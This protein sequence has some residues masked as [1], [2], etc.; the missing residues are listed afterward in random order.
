MSKYSNLR[1]DVADR[2]LLTELSKMVA[3]STQ[4]LGSAAYGCNK[5]IVVVKTRRRYQDLAFVFDGM[6]EKCSK[7]SRC[8]QDNSWSDSMDCNRRIYTLPDKLEKTLVITNEHDK[9]LQHSIWSPATQVRYQQIYRNGRR[10]W[11]YK[12]FF[13]IKIDRVCQDLDHIRKILRSR[14][15]KQDQETL[16]LLK[17]NYYK[18]E[19]V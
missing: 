12:T 16:K 13:V 15:G 3:R 8:S 9:L 7:V 11:R 2:P 6:L 18:Y 5:L 4:G 14:A 1:A 17:R 19:L 10:V